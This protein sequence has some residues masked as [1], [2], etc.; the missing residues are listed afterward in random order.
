MEEIKF[1]KEFCC[2][3]CGLT[4]VSEVTLGK[5]AICPECRNGLY[6]FETNSLQFFYLHDDIKQSLKE[7]G[8]KIHRK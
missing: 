6:V 3:N 5:D 1:K 4:W 2:G 8:K 7:R